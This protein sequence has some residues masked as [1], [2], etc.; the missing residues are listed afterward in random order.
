MLHHIVLGLPTQH[1][2]SITHTH[3]HTHMSLYPG[4][5]NSSNFI[6]C[7]FHVR[8][9]VQHHL[10]FSNASL[11]NYYKGI[12]FRASFYLQKLEQKVCFT[13]VNLWIFELITVTQHARKKQNRIVHQD[14]ISMFHFLNILIYVFQHIF[15]N[16]LYSS[17]YVIY[18]VGLWYIYFYGQKLKSI[19]K[20]IPPRLSF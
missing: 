10:Y 17:L 13:E 5:I 16:K 15:K 18:K 6:C 3:T 20:G 12:S 8:I 1:V 9:H 7:C 4:C 2:L 11:S 14:H 19:N